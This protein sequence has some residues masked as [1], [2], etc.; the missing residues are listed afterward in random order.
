MKYLII[1]LSNLGRS[2]A[3]NLTRIGNEVIGVDIDLHR[4]DLVKQT[5]S[6]AI[7]LDTTDRT[8]LSTL[9]LN[10]MDA[11]IVT[12]GKDFGTSVQTVSLLKSLDAG[13]LI[14][15]SISPIHETVI[16]AI[17]VTEIISPEQ[18]FAANYASQAALGDLFKHWY[19]VT[20][21]HH[22]YKIKTPSVLIGQNIGTINF[23][24]NFG[25]RLVGIERAKETRN[26]IGLKQ[27]QYSVIDHLTN[28]ITLEENDLLILFGK[29]EVLH[30]LAE[31]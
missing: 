31:V 13:K 7:A 25:V 16:R 20:D 10:E 8:A 14:V 12:Y 2:I 17:G 11:I 4:V 24:E 30:K 22:L 3:E 18:D 29:M 28:E 23:E 1:G 27:T 6:G 9:P 21:T 5:I 19:R 15:R 26:L